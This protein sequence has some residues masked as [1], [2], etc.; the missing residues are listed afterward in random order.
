MKI[1]VCISKTPDT[2]AKI[3][4]TDNNT[5]FN[6]AGVQFIINPYD[7][8][9]ALVRALELKE[10]VGADVHLIT[11]GGA[12]CDAII[13]KALALGGDEAFRINADSADSYYIAAQIAAHAKEK[14]YDIIFTGKE[15]IDYN[16]SGIGG[17]VAELL[18]LPYVSIAAKFEL[19]GTVATI[20]RE[21]EGGEEICE[22]SLPVVVSCQKGMAEARIPNMRGIMA[23]RTKPLA[24]VEP[25]AADTLTSVASFELPPAKAGVK[26][27][28]PDDVAE[29]V[30]LLHEEA[31]VI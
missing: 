14:Q 31:K 5:K 23:A 6:E 11:V 8:W 25:V 22:V 4:F 21:I 28:N 26:L 27:I 18:D 15:T 13:R 1:L 2:T 24:V 9:Y 3:A 16:G 19:N 29:L 10:T 7:E 20:N 30:K 17:M 12:D